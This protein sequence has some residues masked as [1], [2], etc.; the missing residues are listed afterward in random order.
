M[1]YVLSVLFTGLL[2]VQPASAQAYIS[3]EPIPSG[4]VI[5][6]SNLA[7]IESAGYSNLER[8]SSRIL[9]E[10]GVVDNVIGVLSSNRSIS[11]INRRNTSVEVADGGFEAVTNPTFVF[12]M[13][14]SGRGGVSA[15][16]VNVLDNAVGY[17]L[18]QGGTVHFSPD[19]PAAYDFPLDYA[20]VSFPRH[21]SGLQAKAFFDYV[22]TVDPALWSGT[23]A[24]FTQLGTSMLFLQ[25]DV[26]KRRFVA[27]LSTAAAT[28]PWATYETLDK[29]GRPATATAGVAFPGNDWIQFPNGDQYLANLGNTTPALVGSLASLRRQHLKAVADLVEAIDRGNL[30]R[31]I[32]HQFKCPGQH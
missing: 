16:D 25:P 1:P 23:F 6:E 19:N 20:V 27:G 14:D 26:S 32:T 30:S 12:T 3:A 31:Y 13:N 18:S 15:E 11:T 7:K 17:V 2:F 4:D 28:Y 21:L 29:H 5:G 24:G 8:W 9:E 10:C 22:G